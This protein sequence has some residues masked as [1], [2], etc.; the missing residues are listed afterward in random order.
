M[1]VY[2]RVQAL[3]RVVFFVSD[4]LIGSLMVFF[5]PLGNSGSWSENL[6]GNLRFSEH[7]KLPSFIFIFIINIIINIIISIIHYHYHHNSSNSHHALSSSIIHLPYHMLIILR[8]G[9]SSYHI[10]MIFILIIVPSKNGHLAG[11][12]GM[13]PNKF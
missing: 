5:N 2:Q 10:I 11:P 8:L 4:F 9:L 7:I 1:L 3:T 13:P 6:G 12:D